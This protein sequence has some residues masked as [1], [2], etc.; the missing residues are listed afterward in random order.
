MAGS[1][2]ARNEVFGRA[3]MYFGALLSWFGTS[4]EVIRSQGQAASGRS[5]AP[6]V[7]HAAALDKCFSPAGLGPG[8]LTVVVPH[9]AGCAPMS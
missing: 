6:E 3:V 8:H 7:L 1:F 4:F 9:E 2:F 5:G